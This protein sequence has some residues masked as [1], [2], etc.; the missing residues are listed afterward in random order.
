MIMSMLVTSSNPNLIESEVPMHLTS[1][2]ILIFLE[3]NVPLD[4]QAN[5]CNP[6]NVVLK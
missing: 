4:I 5:P 3:I 6:G 1:S 2:F